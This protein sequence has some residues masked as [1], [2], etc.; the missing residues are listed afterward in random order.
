MVM[1][2]IDAL[3]G[4]DDHAVEGFSF[5]GAPSTDRL[6]GALRKSIPAAAA[7]FAYGLS[8]VK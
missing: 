7:S 4:D 1:E 5:G 6:P 2:L 3:E 8:E